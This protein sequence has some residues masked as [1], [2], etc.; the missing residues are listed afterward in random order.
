MEETELL[1]KHLQV[2]AA[3]AVG[4][5]GL[6]VAHCQRLT[7]LSHEEHQLLHLGN[8]NRF[9]VLSQHFHELLLR[10]R[11]Q[12]ELYPVLHLGLEFFFWWQVGH[13]LF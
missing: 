8:L 5:V 2:G 6:A 3:A 7:D 9:A 12:Q 10:E 13:E 4:E 1:V 11:A